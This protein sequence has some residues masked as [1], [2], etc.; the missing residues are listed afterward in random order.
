MDGPDV[1]PLTTEDDYARACALTKRVIDDWDPHGL[2]G[3]GAPSDEFEAEAASVVRYIPRMRSTE[4]AAN[5]ISDVFSHY[6]EAEG[7]APDDCRSVAAR[8]FEA[9]GRAGLIG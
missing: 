6:F 8:L 9:L 1:M 4:D 5:A 2:L 7:L 3:S